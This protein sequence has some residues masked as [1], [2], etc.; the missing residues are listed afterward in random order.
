MHEFEE[1]IIWLD[2][3]TNKPQPARKN[4]VQKKNFFRVF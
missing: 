3:E 4:S 1:L 2:S